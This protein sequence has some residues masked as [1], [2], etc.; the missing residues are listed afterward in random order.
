MNVS[1]GT[2]GYVARALGGFEI[3]YHGRSILNR[4]WPR[5]K[6]LALLKRLALADGHALHREQLVNELWPDLAPGAGLNNLHKTLHHIRS[7]L[8]EQGADAPLVMLS[9][10]MVSLAP[11]TEVDA[12]RFR[13]L[14]QEALRHPTH[15]CLEEAVEAYGGELLPDD[16]YVDWTMEQR[17]ELRRLHMEVT[18][19]LGRLYRSEGHL[20]AA[21]ERY[22]DVVRADPLDEDAHRNLVELYAEM[23]NRRQALRQYEQLEMSLAEELGTAPSR[24][25]RAAYEHVL[26]G[27]EVEAAGAEPTDADIPGEGEPTDAADDSVPGVYGRDAELARARQ[28]MAS[29]QAGQGRVV[30]VRGEAGIG[31]THLTEQ[32]LRQAER[33]GFRALVSHCSPL[34][35][36]V[37]YQPFRDMLRDAMEDPEVEGFARHS[38]YLRLLLFG[39]EQGDLQS[40]DSNAFHAELFRE[41]HRLVELL[42]ERQPLALCVDDL[43]AADA[44]SVRLL[45]Y[46]ARRA[47][48][49]RLLILVSCRAE[50][51]EQHPELLELVSSLRREGVLDEL[52]L[53]PMN[54]EAMTG[55]VEGLLAPYPVDA[56]LVEEVIERSEGNPLFAGELVRTFVREGWAAVAGD[57]WVRQGSGM[58][59]IPTAVQEVVDLRMRRLNQ[60]AQGELQVAALM[61]REFGYATVRDVLSLAEPDAL[62]A[63]EAC[64]HANLIEE[65]SG[66]YRF[67]HDLLR[68]AIARGLT[69][70]RRQVLHKRIAQVLE[71]RRGAPGSDAEAIAHHYYL[72]D[73]PWRAAPFLIEA[74]QAAASV[75]ANDRA[76]EAYERARALLAEHPSALPL[77]EQAALTEALGDL[78]RRRGNT[79]RSVELFEESN[80]LFSELGDQEA[81]PRTR[82]KAALGEIVL[83]RMGRAKEL[84]TATLRDLSEQSP[85]NV[86]ARTHYLLAQLHWHSGE[87][88]D[89]LAAAEQALAAAR[90]SGAPE[91]RAQACE[92]LAL[93]CH[94][95]GDWQRGVE[96][97]LERH[98]LKVPGFSTDEAFDAHL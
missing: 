56:A 7:A 49:G 43:H 26:R 76:A 60:A 25:V 98:T 37:A 67:R 89:A 21:V 1:S 82:G 10:E 94:S 42:A 85:A 87:N 84:I 50:E 48:Q 46:L 65:T 9:G 30:L 12:E 75:F 11:G 44:D 68:D 80:R 63:L 40:R 62:D 71:A 24:E 59:P 70:A 79:A 78:E 2:R 20:E 47:P 95:L 53:A 58:T 45:H 17:E 36:A 14:A 61:G 93:A 88:R 3:R 92:V 64:L 13:E 27:E 16:V 41:V 52:D 54:R 81:A 31:K 22:Q 39:M 91:E 86:V 77:P 90:E 97:E 57:R 8:A 33:Q 19:C 38:L 74:G 4:S 32:I 69:R 5:R 35:T 34:E 55:F 6:A 51:L 73:E 29:A 28:A 66:G 83:G 23:G 96:L 18:R 15:A 72:G